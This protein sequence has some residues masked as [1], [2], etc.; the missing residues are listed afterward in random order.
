MACI[1]NP[2]PNQFTALRALDAIQATGKP[3]KKPVRAYPCQDCHRWHLTSKKL[4]GK[5]L[6]RWERRLSKVGY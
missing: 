1:K 4:A 2:Y 6:P 3:G 5:R